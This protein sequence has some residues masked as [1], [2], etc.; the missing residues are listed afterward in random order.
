MRGEEIREKEHGKE[1]EKDTDGYL[2]NPEADDMEE[3]GAIEKENQV[4]EGKTGVRG[5][6]KG[7]KEKD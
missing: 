2:G 1:K 7:R 5:C 3:R 6:R 4:R